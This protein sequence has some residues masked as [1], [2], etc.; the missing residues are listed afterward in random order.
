MNAYIK[1]MRDKMKSQKI[2][3]DS[4]TRTLT[5]DEKKLQQTEVAALVSDR[6]SEAER[7]RNYTLLRQQSAKTDALATGADVEDIAGSSMMKYIAFGGLIVYL[8]SGIILFH[9]AEGWDWLVSAYFLTT[10]MTT[11]GYGDFG[12]VTDEGKMLATVYI[13]IGI[14]AIAGMLGILADDAFTD[15]GEEMEDVDTS[16]GNYSW[17]WRILWSLCKAFAIM[18]VGALIT[19]YLDKGEIDFMDAWYFGVVTCTTVGY[20]DISP[21]DNPPAMLFGMFYMVV[22]TIFVAGSVGTV[23]SVIVE[24]KQAEARERVLKKGITSIEELIDIDD[25]GDGVITLAEFVV[26][27][28]EKMGLVSPDELN[29]ISNEFD[30]YADLDPDGEKKIHAHDLMKKIQSSASEG[31]INN[32]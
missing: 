32:A 6:T 3:F 15:M 10:T 5:E 21:K 11:V 2:T 13:L 29:R 30:Q 27:K 7:D 18:Y 1:H 4:S 9:M 17:V 16:V 31:S 22:G 24:R 19:I 26:W 28:V 12:P 25:D 14:G 23:L 20:G 8:A